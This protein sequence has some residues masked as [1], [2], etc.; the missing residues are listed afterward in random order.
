MLARIVALAG[1]SFPRAPF[2]R[3]TGSQRTRLA[4]GRFSCRLFRGMNSCD[5]AHCLACSAIRAVVDFDDERTIVF[6]FDSL[7]WACLKAMIVFVAF[8]LVD[9][10]RHIASVGS[11]TFSPSQSRFQVTVTA[12]GGM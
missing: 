9:E 10:I 8:F 2:L 1:S 6:L 12:K 11:G 7:N 3:V 5:V 4:V